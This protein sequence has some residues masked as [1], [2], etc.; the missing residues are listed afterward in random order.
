MFVSL[1]RFQLYSR[2]LS[3]LMSCIVI[4]EKPEEECCV[5][6][7]VWTSDS[8]GFAQTGTLEVAEPVILP[9]EGYGDF[10]QGLVVP[11]TAMKQCAA[12]LLRFNVIIH[13]ERVLDYSTPPP[14]Q[15]ISQELPQRCE[16]SAG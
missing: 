2:T 16:W 13:L 8:D 12:E 4:K 6:L 3:L 14:K 9:E 10:L 15:S 1:S 5:C 11:S 7:W